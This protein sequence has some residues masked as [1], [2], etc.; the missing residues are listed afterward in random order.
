[1]LTVKWDEEELK[2]AVVAVRNGQSVFSVV[3]EQGKT[4][5][6]GVTCVKEELAIH[7]V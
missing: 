6:D 4:V 5:S 3:I 7:C 1:M 2:E